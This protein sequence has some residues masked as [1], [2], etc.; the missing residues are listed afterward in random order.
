[1][2]AL[3]HKIGYHFKQPELL[4]LALT[5]PSNDKSENN[6]R[7]EFLGDSVLGMVIAELLYDL[8]PDEQE[9]ELAR[10]LSSLVRGETC[11]K[12]ASSIALGD[13]ILMSAGEA[14]T[15][16]RESTSNLEDA[17]E[18]LI[19]AIYLDGG[20]GAAKQFILPHWRPLAEKAITAPKDSKTA[21]QEWAQARGLPIPTYTVTHQTGSA[22]APEFTIEVAVEGCGAVSAMGGSKRAAEQEAARLLLEKAATA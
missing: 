14:S 9:G 7:L 18:A 1:M 2:N 19:A 6:Q 16:G 4:Q 20:L 3:Q 22:H 5:H 17:L 8:F 12:V 13:A 10:R 21:L 15:G 11:A